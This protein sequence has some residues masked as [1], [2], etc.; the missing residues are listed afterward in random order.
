MWPQQVWD[1]GQVSICIIYKLRQQA[2]V[3][4]HLRFLNEHHLLFVHR[5]KPEEYQASVEKLK[6]KKES[7]DGEMQAEDS[8]VS[9]TSS[10]DFFEGNDGTLKGAFWTFL[11]I[12]R[13]KNDFFHWFGWVHTLA[14][15]A[16]LHREIMPLRRAVQCA[17]WCHDGICQSWK[18]RR[19]GY[20]YTVA[21]QV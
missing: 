3:F 19:S 11:P 5:S 7:R 21:V 2:T 4:L 12:F 6:E 18:R 10:Q 17:T 8:C 20:L 13:L 16:T 9:Q 14:H 15:C 1:Q